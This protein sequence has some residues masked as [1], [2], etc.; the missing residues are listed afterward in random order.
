MNMLAPGK[1]CLLYMGSLLKYID[2]RKIA[3]NDECREIYV[4]IDFQNPGNN[5]TT[6]QMGVL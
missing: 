6:V 2:D 3:I 4:N 1:N 5:I